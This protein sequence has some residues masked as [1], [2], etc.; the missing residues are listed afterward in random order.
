MSQCGSCPVGNWQSSSCPSRVIV[1]R[2]NCPRDSCPQG[3][4]PRGSCLRGNCPRTVNFI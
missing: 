4:C 1:L 2:A 3:I